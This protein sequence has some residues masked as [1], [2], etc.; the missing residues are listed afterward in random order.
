MVVIEKI[1]I[2]GYRLFD[3]VTISFHRGL[4]IVVGDNEAG[5]TTLLEAL[6]LCLT[7]R[8][9]GRPVQDELNPFWFHQPTVES[10]FASVT[11]QARKLPQIVIEVF[12]E[13]LDALQR[14]RG[15]NNSL[16][17]DCPGVSITIAPAAE[18]SDEL[19][20]YLSHDPTVLPV[21]FYASDWCTFSD[22]PVINRPK[23]LAVSFIDSRTV[24]SSSGIDYHLREILSEHLTPK[25]RAQV[26]IAYRKSRDEVSRDQLTAINTRIAA[27]HATLHDK[28]IGLAMDQSARSSWESGVAP[29]VGSIPFGMSGQGQQA[30]VKIAL[31][32]SRSSDR[33]KYILVEEPENHL[34]HTSLNRL[35]NRI[36]RLASENEQQLF[37]T[38]HSSFVLNRLGLDNLILIH[39]GK[40]ASLRNLPKDTVKYFQKLPGYD[41]LRLVLAE[42]L[43]LVEGPSDEIVFEQAFI[44]Q[45][46]DRPIERGIDVLA[47]GGVALRRS[48]E[49]CREL[50]RRVAALRDNDGQSPEHWA[51][52]LADYLEDGRRELF[53]GPVEAGR[54]LEPQL[55]HINGDAYLRSEIFA[56]NGEKS[57]EEWMIENKTEAALRIADS[58]KEIKFPRFMLDAIEFVQ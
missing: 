12:F 24:R 31:A 49:V 19:A 39:K 5:K 10:Y 7:G 43:V 51:A 45:H 26:S 15:V 27:E 28:P 18:Y 2:Q 47:M 48:L 38:T 20:E 56:Y 25:E 37:I 9:N 42:S 4:N 13:D 58:Q 1:R 17:A 16:R 54:T 14:L 35:I 41:T 21:E 36:E 52:R 22:Q 23:E 44:K 57:T 8:I 30:S 53:V 32:M 11:H 50:E 3:D 33:A 6:N 46:G 40:T 34:S 55:I 29:H